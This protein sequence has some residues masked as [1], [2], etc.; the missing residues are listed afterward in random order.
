[1]TDLKQ[2]KARIA[3]LRE[4]EKSGTPKPWKA[5]DNFIKVGTLQE[6]N[7][8]NPIEGDSSNDTHLMAQSRNALPQL[9]DALERA[10]V[11]IAS[12]PCRCS[13]S[14]RLSGHLIGCDMLEPQQALADIAVILSGQQDAN[15]LGK[16]EK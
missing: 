9:L 2:I 14:E 10:V 4:I 12:T 7:T 15:I 8:G 6:I 1:M 3:E 16:D 5:F 11:A 13:V